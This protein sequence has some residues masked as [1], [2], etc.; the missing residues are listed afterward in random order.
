MFD[1]YSLD[2]TFN[3]IVW[4]HSLKPPVSLWFFPLFQFHC[5]DSKEILYFDRHEVG[6]SF[7]F[8][9][10]DS[11][12]TLWGFQSI[13]PIFQFHCMDSMILMMA[14]RASILSFLSIPLYGFLNVPIR[15]AGAT[16]ADI[17]SIPLYGF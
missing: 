8:H 1:R 10:M 2:W 11:S 12:Y 4:I 17:L 5:M 13:Y 16:S 15:G 14:L 6:P 3:S 9:C 7:Q